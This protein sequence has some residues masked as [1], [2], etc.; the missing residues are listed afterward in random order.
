MSLVDAYAFGRGFASD[1]PGGVVAFL[2]SEP[3][4]AC[5]DMQL[6]LTNASL[7]AWPWFPGLRKP[8]VD[9]FACRTVMLHPQ[10]RGEIRLASA[11][12]LVAPR[13]DQHFLA[14]RHDWH[15]LRKTLRTVREIV[16]QP[17]LARFVERETS[18]GPDVASDAA[19]DAFI[20]KTAITVHHPAGT[21]RMGPANDPLAVTDDEGR[22]FGVRGLR[23][24]DASLMPDLTS[25]NIN[26]PVIMIAEKIADRVRGRAALEPAIG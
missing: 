13:I 14:E 3:H 17:A 22:V 1:I 7:P 2:K 5:P 23:V 20:R 16:G 26:A 4:A 10:S 9:G 6:L 18:P 8:F 12:P 25:G 19:L 21:C 24:V 11:D 15:V